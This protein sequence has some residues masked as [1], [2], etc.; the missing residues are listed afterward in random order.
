MVDSSFNLGKALVFL[1]IA[2]VIA[3]P[4]VFII[5]G[6]S[7]FEAI[8]FVIAAVFVSFFSTGGSLSYLYR[9]FCDII[10][11]KRL[12]GKYGGSGK[13]KYSSV[14]GDLAIV[15]FGLYSAKIVS[16]SFSNLSGACYV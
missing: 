4:L 9:M 2:I 1:F 8:I 13:W 7:F 16:S 6:V 12:D 15:A 5:V 3:S 14:S 11:Y 10:N